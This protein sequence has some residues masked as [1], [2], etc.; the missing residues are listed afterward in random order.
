MKK[1]FARLVP[2]AVA[3]LILAVFGCS[4]QPDTPSSAETGSPGAGPLT[5]LRFGPSGDLPRLTQ[6]AAMFD[7]PMIP[8]GA[9]DQVPEGALNLTPDLPGRRVWLNQ[10]TLAFVPDKPLAGSHQITAEL[11]ADRLP[12]ALSGARLKE[13]AAAEIRLPLLGVESRQPLG[14]RD[15]DPETAL[16]PGWRVTFNQPPDPAGLEKRAF[17]TWSEGGAERKSAALAQPGPGREGL[18][19]EFTAANPLPRDTAYRLV[20]QSGARSLAGP[21]PAPELTLAEGRTYGPF[22]IGWAEPDDPDLAA[23]SPYWGP[24]T[25]VFSNPVD[26]ARIL[27]L[28]R[29][30][31][32]Y[33]LEDYPADPGE[34]D[35]ARFQRRLY[36]SGLLKGETDYALTLDPDARDLYGQ[37][38]QTAGPLTFRTRPYP[39]DVRFGLADSYGLLETA[40]PPRLRLTVTNLPQVEIEGFALTA[41]EAIHFLAAGE[42]DPKRAWTGNNYSYDCGGR[43]AAGTLEAAEP[44]RLV[45]PVPG[46]AKDGRQVLPLD[47]DRL[48]GD[49][50]LGRFLVVRARYKDQENRQTCALAQISDLGLTVKTGPESGLIWVTNLAEARAWP[51]ADLELRDGAGRVLWRGR[52]GPDGLAPLPGLEKLFR[53]GRPD[54]RLFAVARAGGQMVLWPLDWQDSL[55]NWRWPV[56][57]YGLYAAENAAREPNYWLLNALPLYRP[58]ETAKFKL[59]VRQGRGDLMREPIGEELDLEIRDPLGEKAARVRKKTGPFGALSHEFPLPPEAHLGDWTVWAGPADGELDQAGSF[60]VLTYRPPALEIKIEGLP[61]QAL[62]GDRAELN[63]KADYHFGAPAAGRPA[64]Y[65][66]YYQPAF[67]RLPGPYADY[68]IQDHMSRSEEEDGP[69]EPEEP[70]EVLVS[71]V[72]ELNRNGSLGFA[73][74]LAAPAGRPPRPRFL[75]AN[76]TVTDVDGRPVSASGRFLVHP[77][78]LYAGLSVPFLGRAGED[79]AVKFIAAD[80]EGRP[81][82]GVE[83]GL[84]L[85][86]R[87]WR[88][89]RRK[90]PGSAYEYVSRLTDD[91]VAETR[92][93]SGEGPVTWTVAPDRPGQYWVLAELKDQAGRLTRAA[94]SFYV[95]GDGE[96]G[97]LPGREDEPLTLLPDKREYQPGEVAR[98][99]V[100]SPFD[101]GEG[102]LTVERA[103]LRRSETFRIT[104]QAPVLEVPIEAWDTPNVFVSVLLARGRLA[105]SPDQRNMDFGKPAL[106]AGYAE[107]AVPGRAALLDVKVE[108][109]PPEVGPGEEVTVNLSVADHLGQPCPQAEVALIAADAAVIQ[110]AGDSTYHP[111]TSFHRAYPLLVQTASNL[112]SLVSREN[113][114]LKGGDPGGGGG[115]SSEQAEGLR[116]LFAALAFFEPSLTPDQEGRVSVKI[117]MPENLTTFKI[118]A[119]ATGHGRRSGTGQS[120]VLVTRDLLVRQSLPP[121]AAPDDEFSASAVV[122]NRGSRSGQARVTLAGENF[123]LLEGEGVKTVAVE[124][125][126]SREV[127]FRVQAGPGPE[128]R[129]R[130]GVEMG[131][132]RDLAE[133][134]LP[135]IPANPLTTQGAFER[136]TE[137]G[138][139]DLALPPGTDPDRGGLEVEL[140]PSLMGVM[141]GPLEWLQAYPHGCVEQTVSRAWAELL[142]LTDRLGPERAETARSRVRTALA[143]LDSW[144]VDGGYNYWPGQSDWSTRSVYLTAYVLDFKLAARKAGFEESAWESPARFLRFALGGGQEKAW[145]RWHSP[146]AVR[147]AKLY[148]LAQLARAGDNVAARLEDFL[149]RP[150]ELD[151]FQLAN[152][153]RAVHFQP[154]LAGRDR[155]KRDLLGLIDRQLVLTPAGAAPAGQ[156]EIW[157]SPTRTL[158]LVVL[159]LAEAAPDHPQLPGLVRRLAGTARDGHFGSTQSTAVALSALAEAASALEPAWP[160]LTARARLGENPPL[161]QG[162]FQSFQDQ[163]LVGQAAL[164]DLGAELNIDLEGRGLVWTAVRLKSAPA[165]P[166]LTAWSSGG[167]NLTRDFTVAAPEPGRPGADR[168]RRGQVV[169]ASIALVVPEA[170]YNV[171]LED[172]VPAGFEPVNFN[173]ADADQTLLDLVDPGEEDRPRFWYDHQEI[174]PDRVAVYADYLPPGV[175]TFNYLARAATAGRYLTPGPRAEEM[176]APENAGRGAGHIVVV[177]NVAD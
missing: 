173:L 79:R 56:E 91:K 23:W 136:F 141:R 12:A 77:A 165:R 85:Y 28:M 135:L 36:M 46:G 38:L 53:E 112:L 6:I 107:L 160:D 113:F 24:P 103:G 48:F 84:S 88:S 108:V 27:P 92:L 68:G 15:L 132:D 2:G 40:A 116:R 5:L 126:Q 57:A 143:R 16:S 159:V 163:P 33:D 120:S 172:H 130:F 95:A 176:Y 138:K 140:A 175:Y 171:V 169:R 152:L 69:E 124:P 7:Q 55:S 153:L 30:S 170:R 32:E 94:E 125:G 157:A 45:I 78:A 61:D 96:V 17:F 1:N 13:D 8:L 83:A 70:A 41:E 74:D 119:V 60:K 63:L 144:E 166:D 20:L 71:S 145:P 133:F 50:R 21:V 129:F 80:L 123:T 10:Y 87:D 146:E 121:Y 174:W 104:G 43:A 137:S 111:E 34:E 3:V 158:A 14:E 139:I 62:A 9:Y 154:A 19:F 177:E 134:T 4:G 52:S 115:L 54:R 109:Q 58:G 100:Q 164:S 167:F 150:A 131:R 114:G 168:F 97:W 155:I 18:V 161:V 31:P 11:R 128:A 42:E 142:T 29:L 49:R 93:T 118:F 110:L 156:G 39:P 147:S 105:E 75:T 76:A 148:A 59:I 151:L 44:A 99:L 67:F 162:R 81:V 149:S 122:S 22:T 82:P 89:V 47:L 106:R 25:L 64:A 117:K 66:A 73:V 37:P 51:G 65:S 35:A 98:I 26:L 72:G 86:R 127:A 101:Q 102:L 90:T